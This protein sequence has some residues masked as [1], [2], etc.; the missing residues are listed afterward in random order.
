MVRVAETVAALAPRLIEALGPEDRLL[1]ALRV[2]GEESDPSNAPT[3]PTVLANDPH[4]ALLSHFGS[5]LHRAYEH[6][7]ELAFSKLVEIFQLQAE[8]SEAIEKRLE[9]AEANVRREQAERL[10]D[11]WDRAEE[12]AARGGSK[13]EILNSLMQSFMQGQAQRAAAPKPPSNGKGEPT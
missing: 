9:R 12:V 2:G 1:R 8:R 3:M 13:D 5:L 10:D 4:A 11:M 6:S 7:T